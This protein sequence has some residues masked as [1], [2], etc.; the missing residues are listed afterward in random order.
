[1]VGNELRRLSTRR[2]TSE[3]QRRCNTWCRWIRRLNLPASSTAMAALD[4]VLDEYNR[5]QHAAELQALEKSGAI[6]S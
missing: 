2:L 1:M 4:E 5:R 3:F 6:G